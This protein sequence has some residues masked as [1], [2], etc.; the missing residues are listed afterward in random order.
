[1]RDGINAFLSYDY[2]W[3]VPASADLRQEF[4]DVLLFRV[5]SPLTMDWTDDRAPI[6]KN[7]PTMASAAFVSGGDFAVS[8]YPGIGDNAIDYDSDAISNQR[9]IVQCDY[10]GPSGKYVHELRVHHKKTFADFGGFSGAIVIARTD[11]G[12]IPAGVVI[13]A[14]SGHTNI[15]RFVD[16]DAL[17]RSLED[18]SAQITP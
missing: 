2:S 9:F 15:M 16:A 4:N 13:T 8:G 17:Y 7:T 5:T 14:G 1:M 3:E 10:V 11:H 18:F 6:K 12:L